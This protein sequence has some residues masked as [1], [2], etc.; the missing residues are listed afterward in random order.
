MTLV[1]PSR[2]CLKM[3][4]LEDGV[5]FGFPQV[6]AKPRHLGWASGLLP[7][8]GVGH[9]ENALLTGKAIAGEGQSNVAS[10]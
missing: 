3:G 1:N 8:P 4:D 5:S 9:A 6:E 2:V 10:I 7:M